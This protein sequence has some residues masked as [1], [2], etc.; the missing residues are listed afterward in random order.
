MILDRCPRCVQAFF[1]PFQRRLRR[2]RFRHLWAALLAWVLAQSPAKLL[3]RASATGGRHR[4]SLGRFLGRCDWPAEDLLQ[5]QALHL[6]RGLKPQPGETLCLRIDDTRLAKRGKK[7][8]HLSKLWDHKQQRF[9]RG[10]L[11]VCAAWLLRGGVIPW[12]FVRWRPEKTAGTGYLKTTAIA[13]RLIRDLPAFGGLR[14]RVLFDAFYL[15]PAVTQACQARGF[16][17]FSV[18]ASHRSFR[19]PAGRKAKLRSLGPGRLRHEGRRVRRRRHRGW[20][21]M[22]VTSVTGHLSRIGPVRL[23]FAKRPKDPWKNTLC[24]ATDEAGLEARAV[25]AAYEERWWI[26]VLFKD[27]K[28]SLGLGGYQVLSERGIV[29]HL[30]RSGLAHQLLTHHGLKAGGAQAGADGKTRARPPL[31]RRLEGLGAALRR[32]RID[33]VVKRT[34]H[35]H[36]RQ[37]LLKLLSMLVT[38]A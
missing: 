17:W 23:V 13:A 28:G 6:L 38:A 10:H 16:T 12:R 25:L 18:A 2:P 15:C 11:V 5:L 14:V 32:E 34:R 35:V 7:M 19:T 37:K 21:W 24:G 27:L 33:T 26:E 1:A 29:N 36:V 31:D 22:R 8:A 20:A 4:T 30:H 9:V 3:H